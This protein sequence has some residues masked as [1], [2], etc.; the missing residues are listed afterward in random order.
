V[1]DDWSTIHPM[2]CLLKPDSVECGLE[3]M[4]ETFERSAEFLVILTEVVE[5]KALMFM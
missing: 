5:K 4:D 1:D 3:I 2:V